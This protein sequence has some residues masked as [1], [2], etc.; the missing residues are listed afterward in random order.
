MKLDISV[1]K[2]VDV[3]LDTIKIE[4]EEKFKVLKA[5]LMKVFSEFLKKDKQIFDLAFT[6]PKTLNVRLIALNQD[7]ERYL[8][9][10]IELEKLD[11]KLNVEIQKNPRLR[12]AGVRIAKKQS[13]GE[14]PP[15]WLPISGNTNLKFM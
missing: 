13:T 5:D 2:S 1:Q 8:T 10:K 6:E 9:S 11:E 3:D 14:D 4:T 15:N 12:E 7:E